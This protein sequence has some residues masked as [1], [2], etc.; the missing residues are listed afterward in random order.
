MRKRNYG[1][2][3]SSRFLRFYGFPEALWA[4]LPVLGLLGLDL[5]PG[6]TRGSRSSALGRLRG[7]DGCSHGP[8]VIDE[9]V[10]KVE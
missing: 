5:Q 10:I 6:L 8:F 9:R 3:N 7:S 2:K 4:W 1:G